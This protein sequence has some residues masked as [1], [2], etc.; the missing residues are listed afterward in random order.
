MAEESDVQAFFGRHAADYA[1][2]EG[3]RSGADLAMLVAALM[4][5]QGRDCLDVATGTGFTAVALAQ[6]GGRVVAVDLTAP[7]LA[8]TERLAA[9]AGTAVRVVRGDAAKLPFA[10]ASFDRLSCR[11]AAHHF[12]DV[13][14]FLA[15]ARRVLRPGGR[16]AIADMAPDATCAAFQDHIERLR[17]ASHRH[18]LSP[19]EWRD[20]VQDA[21]FEGVAVELWHERQTFERWYYP[22]TEVAARRRIE[23]EM[24]GAAPRVAAALGLRRE[25]DGSWS[26]VKQRAVVSATC[27]VCPGDADGGRRRQ[28]PA[29]EGA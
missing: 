17:D 18:A 13:P 10:D 16:L 11:R 19:D 3:H 24:A 20:A 27:P 2:S 1:Q 4:P 21:G 23:A 8:E 7:M 5:V 14:A 25:A 22:V 26:L 6:A 28:E 15:E 9:E 29:R 12:D